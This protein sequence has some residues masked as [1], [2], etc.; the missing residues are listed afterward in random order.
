MSFHENIPMSKKDSSKIDKKFHE[1]RVRTRA[2]GKENANFLG[3]MGSMSA[4][5]VKKGI[6]T[7]ALEKAK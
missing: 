3:K 2:G 4:K 1:E 6:K 5:A 7:E